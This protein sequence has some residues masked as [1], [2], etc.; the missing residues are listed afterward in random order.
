MMH[1]TNTVTYI[2]ANDDESFNQEI[3]WQPGA[4][5]VESEHKT[6]D[7]DSSIFKTP[8]PTAS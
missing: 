6:S 3:K 8:T 7:S 4:S 5:A 1:A 2:T